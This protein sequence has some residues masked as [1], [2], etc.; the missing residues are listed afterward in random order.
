MRRPRQRNRRA[1]SSRENDDQRMVASGAGARPMRSLRILKT[2]LGRAEALPTLPARM[3]RL[4]P[5][6]YTAA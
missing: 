6:R 3:A 4:V 5:R 2:D 1:P